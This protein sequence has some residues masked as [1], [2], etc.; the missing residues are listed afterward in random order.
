MLPRMPHDLTPAAVDG[1]YPRPQLVRTRW[2]ELD[3]EW[4]FAFDPDDVGRDNGW[5]QAPEAIS[6]TIVVPFP[7][8]SPASGIG[9]TI[10]HRVMWY[11]RSVTADEVSQAG[12][13]PGRR[14]VLH[15][16]AV[17]YRCEVWIDGRLA[18]R[19]EGGHTPFSVEVPAA[20]GFDIVVRVED[21]AGDLAQPRGKQDWQARRHV[22]WYD[23]TSGIWQP[24]WLESVPQQHLRSV[25]WRPDVAR[26]SVALEVELAHDPAPG[27][28]LHVTLHRADGILS[29]RTIA[30]TSR[31]V[32]DAIVLPA[33][34]NGQDLDAWLWSPERPNLIDATLVLE[35]PDAAEDRDR[36]RSYFGLRSIGAAD[37]RFLVNGR[38]YRIRGVLS[39]GYWPQ[40]HLAAPSADALRAEVQLAKDLGF[41]TVRVHQKIEDPRFLYWADRLGVLVWAEMPSVYEF[42]TTSARRLMTEWADAV[43]R[44]LSHPS[45]AVWVPLNESW[46]VND[47]ATEPRQ[48]ELARTLWHLTKTLDG[49]RLA[50]SNDGW[51][52]LRSDL[53]TVHD[54]ENDA[55]RL[56]QSYGTESATARSL[57]GIAPNGKRMLVGTPEEQAATAER[58]V[59]LS[60][61][62][63]V[64]VDP[65]DGDA[66]GYRLVESQ[67]HLEEH[68]TALFMAVHESAGLAGWCYTQLTD[69]AQ[70]T[71][72]LADENRV[73][74]LPIER[75]RSIVEGTLR[76]RHAEP[77][78]GGETAALHQGG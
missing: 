57:D 76:P 9:D 15:F 67:A 34:R 37:G 35:S 69:T 23:R 60:E 28:R 5:A 2:H 46:G 4:A 65:A 21:E 78:F 22:V 33:L 52:H 30:L 66:W 18:A 1:A 29:E 17:D 43:T 11:R 7:P 26:A 77:L 64:S 24:V 31:R 63:G 74:K 44:D 59:V 45:I 39:Q 20:D 13:G 41:N 73:P 68:L 56:L 12:H 70:E 47:V 42:S 51:E 10:G 75:L 61:F 53:F 40:S 38:P 55:E 58:P 71:N 36:V 72:G 49:T 19:H 54:Y 3:G 6:G 14:L 25:V 48:Q 27:T 62:G 8:E 32:T 16:G 50:I